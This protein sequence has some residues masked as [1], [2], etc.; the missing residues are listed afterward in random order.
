MRK[1]ARLD[2]KESR[3]AEREAALSANPPQ[4]KTKVTESDMA[5]SVELSLGET[6]EV[7]DPDDSQPLAS[8]RSANVAT[9]REQQ[10]LLREANKKR[11]LQPTVTSTPSKTVESGVTDTAVEMD[12]SEITTHSCSGSRA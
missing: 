9:R 5:L 6:M 11:Y 2:K 1:Q 8:L 4:K 10:K 7:D 12:C 3:R